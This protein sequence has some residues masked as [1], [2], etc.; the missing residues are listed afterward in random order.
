MEDENDINEFNNNKNEITPQ[1][2]SNIFE[3]KGELISIDTEIINIILNDINKNFILEDFS[4]FEEENEVLEFFYYKE[5]ESLDSI[6][7]NFKD[8][9]TQKL[10]LHNFISEIIEEKYEYNKSLENF[11]NKIYNKINEIIE[12]IK[13]CKD[14]NNYVLSEKY[15][16][17]FQTDK[18]PKFLEKNIIEIFEIVKLVNE[19]N[20][21]SE[22]ICLNKK[23]NEYSKLDIDYDSFIV[24][25]YQILN[26]E[27]IPFDVEDKNVLFDILIFSNLKDIH[28]NPRIKKIFI[29]N[30]LDISECLNYHE[31]ISEFGKVINDKN[32]LEFIDYKLKDIFNKYKFG[33]NHLYIIA[34]FFYLVINK[35]N[36]IKTYNSD[37]EKANN[38][39]NNL[40][41][42]F[43]IKILK[44][45][46]INF[47]R[48]CPNKEY[49]METYIHLFNYF[50]LNV[51]QNETGEKINKYYGAEDVEKKIKNTHNY[52]YISEYEDL[53]K[54]I[55]TAEFFSSILKI[56]KNF[57]K[58]IPLTNNRKSHTITILISGFL[59]QL[60][61]FDS[62]KLFYD[63]DKENSNYYL[64]KWPSSNVLTFVVRTLSNIFFSGTSFLCCYKKAECAGKILALFLL[65]NKEFY[66]CQINLVGFSLGCHVLINCLKEL[67][68]FRNNK[69]MINNVLL[70]GGATVIEDSDK[71]LWRNIFREN[72]AGRIINCF[73]TFDDVLSYLFK[74]CIMKTPIGIQKLNIKDENGEYQIVEDYDFSDIRLGHLEYRKKFEIILKRIDFF[75]WK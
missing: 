60:D 26:K 28:R 5:K 75:N 1:Y 45:V 67:N 35:M 64:F 72:V 39:T 3:F 21:K 73:S 14:I 37:E 32:E 44:N 57:F 69:F 63:F 20:P 16:K 8:N 49:D 29:N 58:L 62:W 74:V 46:L 56:L 34:S 54:E 41:Q 19:F 51:I 12:D 52:K 59:S 48:Y 65:S 55:K 70:M 33:D 30:Y 13:N 9:E 18:I 27:K 40:N 6:D 22:D 7:V 50:N 61:D 25:Y 68:E 53:I 17:K 38:K 2:D 36:D 66:D 15:I 24:Y 23:K 43:M 31:G 42:P 11:R 4:L 71:I 10:F 47:V